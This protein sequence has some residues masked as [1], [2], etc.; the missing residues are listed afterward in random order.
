MEL[1]TIKKFGLSDQ[2][3][4]KIKEQIISLNIKPGTRIL[5]DKIALKLGVSKTPVREALKKLTAKGL[6]IYN[7]YNNSYRVVKYTKKDIE[8]I[9]NIRISLEVLASKLAVNNIDDKFISDV[10][11][12]LNKV[13]NKLGEESIDFYALNDIKFHHMISKKSENSRLIEMLNNLREQIFYIRRWLTP[14]DLKLLSEEKTFN[15]HI[16][17][18]MS[19][20]SKNPEK[21]VETMEKHLENGKER[22]L[23]WF[24]K[25][26]LKFY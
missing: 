24:E 5:I 12:L 7:D 22:T 21:V 18:F 16:K 19:L 4:E 13:K 8:D 10:D 3:E 2:V 15:E 17:I 14:T 20:K 6:I 25:S 11:E 1:E 23:K 9:Y 26:Q